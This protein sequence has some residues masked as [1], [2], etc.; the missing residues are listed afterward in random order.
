MRLLTVLALVA[1][2]LAIPMPDPRADLAAMHLFERQQEI[3]NGS[4]VWTTECSVEDGCVLVE[5]RAINERDFAV[6]TLAWKNYKTTTRPTTTA[7]TS[8]VKATST[9]KPSVI[10]A[11][12]VSSSASKSSSV[13]SK[14]SSS[15]SPATTAHLIVVDKAVVAQYNDWQ[16]RFVRESPQGEYVCVRSALRR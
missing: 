6:A 4:E 15:A 16:K 12:P 9:P 13:V 3:D 8:N 5:R 1:A 14:S 11:K 10:S 2:A 7:K